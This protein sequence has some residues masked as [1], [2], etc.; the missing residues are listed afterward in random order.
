[1]SYNPDKRDVLLR[2]SESG[3]EV[4]ER[5]GDGWR[6]ADVTP[7]ADASERDILLRLR[8]GSVETCELVNGCWQCSDKP[9]A[10]QP[11][12][13][14]KSA[15][16]V[17][18]PPKQRRFTAREREM[19]IGGLLLVVLVLGLA[20]VLTLTLGRD[21][22][23]ETATAATTTTLWED[24]GRTYTPGV[25]LSEDACRQW[26]ILEALLALDAADAADAAATAA[27]AGDYDSMTASYI[28]IRNYW[29]NGSYLQWVNDCQHHRSTADTAELLDAHRAGAEHWADLKRD[30]RHLLEP[31]GVACE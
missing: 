17:A 12:V 31:R 11:V 19:L 24:A 8:P 18:R 29:R 21:D 3:V 2:I 6:R 9:T 4:F 28:E 10:P 26:G 16:P 23:G 14:S 13:K 27:F 1:M 20:V 15:Q 5:D 7:P 25:A 30:C 22:D